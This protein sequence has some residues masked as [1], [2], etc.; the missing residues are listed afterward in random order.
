M[1]PGFRPGR[2]ILRATNPRVHEDTGAVPHRTACTVHG[3]HSV[4]APRDAVGGRAR[5]LDIEEYRR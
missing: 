5:H 1:P 2:F 4:D 3:D